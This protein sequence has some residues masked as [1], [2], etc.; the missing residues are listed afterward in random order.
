MSSRLPFLEGRARSFLRRRGYHVAIERYSAR[1]LASY[2]FKIATLVDI[3]VLNGTPQLYAAFPNAHLV[4]IDPLPDLTSRSARW[5]DRQAGVTVINMGAGSSETTAEL[6]LAENTSSFL[7]RLD[8]LGKPTGSVAARIAPLD[9]ILS[10]HDITGPLGIKIDTEGFELEV[11]KGASRALADAVFV[12]AEVSLIKRFEA[13][14]RP[15]ELFAE[16]ARH[17]F[18]LR[19]VMPNF[20]HNRYFDALFTRK[21]D[22]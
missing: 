1:Y 20:R 6:T 13:S 11:L 12:I 3:G 15:S 2:D 18:E 17:G 7:K 19:D 10:E 21:N 8:G 22:R 9:T 4:L 16:F 14:Y 5:A